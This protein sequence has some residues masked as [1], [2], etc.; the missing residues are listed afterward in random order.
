MDEGA[1]GFPQALL[2]GMEIGLVTRLSL[3]LS[4]LVVKRRHSSDQEWRVPSVRFMSQ[5]LAIP[6]KATG[7]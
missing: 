1:Q 5:D 3:A 2:D 6:V 7:K 4:K